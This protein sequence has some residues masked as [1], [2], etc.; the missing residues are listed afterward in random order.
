MVRSKSS[1]SLEK[2]LE[3]ST[4]SLTKIQVTKYLSKLLEEDM[5]LGN[6]AAIQ[7]TIQYM[8]GES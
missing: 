2:S 8:E 3:P 1:K 7:R 6:R 5:T 4:K